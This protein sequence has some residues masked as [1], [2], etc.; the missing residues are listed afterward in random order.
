MVTTQMLCLRTARKA[1]HIA[2]DM[3]TGYHTTNVFRYLDTFLKP[4]ASP[5]GRPCS[6]T[7]PTSRW[8]QSIKDHLVVHRH[9]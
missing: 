7:P 1:R 5:S 6:P 9:P 3:T 4:P 8:T 2:T